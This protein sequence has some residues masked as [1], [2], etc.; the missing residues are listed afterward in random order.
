MRKYLLLIVVLF[1]FNSLV[2]NPVGKERARDLGKKFVAA[3][4]MQKQNSDLD[5]AY[6]METKSGEPCFYIR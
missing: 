1:A 3:N 5:L 2:A 6:T 4:F